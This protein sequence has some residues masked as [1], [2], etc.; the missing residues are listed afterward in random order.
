MVCLGFDRTN[1]HNLTGCRFRRNE[2]HATV[3]ES[4][5]R[6]IA[7]AANIVTGLDAGASLANEDFTGRNELAGKTLDAKHLGLAVASV[8][9]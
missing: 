4:K 1:V 9:G 6:V 8:A 5:E 7:T 3:G 2:L